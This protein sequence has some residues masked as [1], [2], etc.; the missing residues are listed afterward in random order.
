MTS[1][2]VV[3]F[4]DANIDTAT[5]GRLLSA[6][7]VGYYN[8]A[9]RFANLPA[10]GIGYIIGRVMFPAYATLQHDLPEFQKTFLS[11]VRRVALFS[12]PVGVGIVV[13]ARP[14]VVGLFGERWEPAVAPLQILAV[15]GLIR[16]FSG[17][18][19]PVLQAAGKPHLVFHLNVWHLVVLCAA[20]FSLTP[21]FGLNGAATAATLAAAASAVPA[22]WLALRILHLPLRELIASVER[23]AVCSVPLAVCL[24]AVEASTRSL[25]A[26]MQL[27]FLVLCGAV[28]YAASVFV[29]ARSEL[30]TIA[31]AFR[32][33]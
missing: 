26:A 18:T 12:L 29:L 20:L 27:L 24:L 32:S 17:T 6:T 31:A 8:V 1:A 16:A 10:T 23:P 30:R 14:I 13:A 11:N 33:P 19:V 22:Y 5:V 28:V 21:P 7:A 9:W 15:F 2:N 4:L 25:P 3:A